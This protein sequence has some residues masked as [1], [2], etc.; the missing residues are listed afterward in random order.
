MNKTQIYQVKKKKNK[1]NF[2]EPMGHSVNQIGVWGFLTLGFGVFFFR[3]HNGPMGFSFKDMLAEG[4]SIS[5][6]VLFSI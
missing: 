4:G 6:D 3:I 2:I 5:F 1:T